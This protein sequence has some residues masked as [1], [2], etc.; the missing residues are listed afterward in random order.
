MSF[1][2]YDLESQ[3]LLK[4]KRN[5]LPSAKQS[6]SQ[7]ELDEIINKTSKQLLVFANLIS[8]FNS[9]RKQI[10]TR[11]D[12]SQLRDDLDE[13]THKIG[14]LGAAINTLIQNVSLLINKKQLND[15]KNHLKITEKQ[16]VIKERVTNEYNE[17]NKQF[18]RLR[19]A[20]EEKKQN[21][22]LNEAKSQDAYNERTPLVGHEPLQ[23]QNQVQVEEQVEDQIEDTDLQYHIALTQE[24]NREIDQV[25]EG[26]QEVNAI[27]KD[28]GELVN[29]QGEQL[30][31]IED[32]ILQLHG[33]TQQAD[34]KLIKAH[35]YQKKKG[36]WT[37][38]L[39]T[40]LC[41]FVLVVVLAILS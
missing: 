31:T 25:T 14:D 32:N 20:Y 37:C 9:R 1:A 38:I 39:L 17:L 12:S 10:G 13:I 5:P 23:E 29:R 15:Q 16:I 2:N 3:T 11:R 41:I 27:F 19:R 7:N 30:D 22:L 21:H 4:L 28:L 24:R 33:N 34:Q 8:Q 40:A 35:E 18:Q 6:E 36:K 26:I